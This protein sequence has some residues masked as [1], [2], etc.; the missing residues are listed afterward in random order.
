MSR[1]DSD[2][3][4]V[5]DLPPGLPEPT[6][7]AV[8]RTWHRIAAARRP[9]RTRPGSRVLV[10]VLAA[11]VVA[12]L[13]VGGAVVF[14]PADAPWGTA[15]P[16]GGKVPRPNLAPAP[17]ET[18]AALNALADAAEDG[19]PAAE[20]RPGQLIYVRHDG[21]AASFHASGGRDIQLGDDPLRDMGPRVDPSKSAGSQDGSL[22][23]QLLELWFEA[24]GM[25]ML[26]VTN[27]EATLD[28]DPAGDR[29]RLRLRGPSIHQ[30]TPAWIAALPTDPDRLRA[31][32][33]GLVGEGGAWSTDHVLW[34]TLQAFYLHSDLLL[35]PAQ[36][37]ALLRSYTG[38]HGI[39]SAEVTV[40][41]RRLVAVRQSEQQSGNEIL[42]DPATGQAVGRR[43]VSLDAG[44][45]VPPASGAPALD[46]NVI[47]QATWTQRVVDRVGDR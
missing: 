14:T 8:S 26:S 47:Y 1:D 10:P 16:G 20:A 15:G 32:L 22:E 24:E 13:A 37:A 17:P 46:P 2:I 12:G 34:T 43:S 40:D 41:G 28:T 5:R 30:P 25:V 11:A 36:R 31:H 6:D 27:G 23:P 45:V 42:F 9:A 38:L 3:I 35:S 19:P 21:W 7:E 18:V 33:R 44:V 4:A 39:T 29:D